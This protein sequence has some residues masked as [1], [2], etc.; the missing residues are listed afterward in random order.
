M[1]AL[2]CCTRIEPLQGQSLD[3]PTCPSILYLYRKLLHV[4]SECAAAGSSAGTVRAADALSS[5]LILSHTIFVKEG[6][7]LL[8]KAPSEDSLAPDVDLV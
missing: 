7:K 1:H 8:Q 3:E 4:H 6:R 2:C 5:L